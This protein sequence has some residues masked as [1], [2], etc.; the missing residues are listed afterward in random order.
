[1]N[2]DTSKPQP[3]A[4]NA[5]DKARRIEQAVRQGEREEQR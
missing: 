2:L 5:E 1:M 4:L 3:R